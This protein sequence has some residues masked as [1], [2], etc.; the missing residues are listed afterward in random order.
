MFTRFDD[1]NQYLVHIFISVSGTN[2][3]QY[4]HIKDDM[5][6]Y[7]EDFHG[8]CIMTNANWGH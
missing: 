4:L 2:Y 5:S 1:G 3:I 8:A 7:G 6:R